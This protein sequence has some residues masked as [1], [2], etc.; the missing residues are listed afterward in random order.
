MSGYAF[1]SAVLARVPDWAFNVLSLVLL[2]GAVLVVYQLVVGSRRLAEALG[3]ESTTVRLYEDL[4]TEREN[5]RRNRAIA[6][7]FSTAVGNAKRLLEYRNKLTEPNTSGPERSFELVPKIIEAVTADVKHLSGEMHRCGLWLEIDG[8]LRLQ[9]GSSGFPIE[10]LH[11]G[12]RLELDRSVAGTC[13]RRSQ[14]LKRDKVREDQDYEVNPQS[15]SHYVSLICIPIR[16]LGVTR[17]VLTIDGMNPMT[18]ADVLIGELY[19]SILE[20]VLAESSRHLTGA[21][22]GGSAPPAGIGSNA[23]GASYPTSPNTIKGE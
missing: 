23:S 18:E 13:F 21:G 2:V 10:Y 6:Y 9:H 8:E 4:A 5:G 19:A 15:N 1:F 16:V 20:G 14:T 17:G 12:R 7:Q 11:G 22:A 3:R